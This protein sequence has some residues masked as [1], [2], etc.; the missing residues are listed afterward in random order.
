MNYCF[1]RIKLQP[2]YT[3]A[4]KQPEIGTCN[5][6]LPFD[7]VPI[8]AQT[9]SLDRIFIPDTLVY[10]IEQPIWSGHLTHWRQT[11]TDLLWLVLVF[12]TDRITEFCKLKPN[13]QLIIRLWWA[14][15]RS[16]NLVRP[17]KETTISL[18][19]SLGNCIE[20]SKLIQYHSLL[21]R[22]CGR[23]SHYFVAERNK[24]VWLMWSSNDNQ[25]GQS[26][27]SSGFRCLLSRLRC[28]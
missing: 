24:R 15:I 28:T 22:T 25:T 27:W 20:I 12:L 5:L 19:K 3:G 17:T 11:N 10:P 8:D 26:R 21:A 23:L 2:F 6:G 18:D 9:D 13:G 7:T 14:F 4:S 1:S 16:R